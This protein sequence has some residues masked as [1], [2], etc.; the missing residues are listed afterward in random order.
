MRELENALIEV[1]QNITQLDP[2]KGQIRVAYADNPGPSWK[3]TDEVLSFFLTSV[4]DS[5][6]QDNFET[7][8]NNERGIYYTQVIDVNISIYGSTS[9]ELASKLRVLIQREDLRR[10]L[11]R[12]KAFPVLKT[13]PPRYV[14]YEYNKQWWQRTDLTLTFN[15]FTSYKDRVEYF[16]SANI[17]IYTDKGDYRYVDVT[18]KTRS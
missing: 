9:R 8:T 14:P 3:H 6:D 16:E 18:T 2:N 13:P 11:T 1:F 7:Y 4:S 5:Y 10:P 12:I 17:G 15:W